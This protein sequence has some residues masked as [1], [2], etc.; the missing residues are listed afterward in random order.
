MLD[1]TGLKIFIVIFSVIGAVVTTV[2]QIIFSY[3]NN[4]KMEIFKVELTKELHNVNIIRS[5]YNKL[6]YKSIEELLDA[7]AE[8]NAFISEIGVDPEYDKD[9]DGTINEFKT[10]RRELSRKSLK[11]EVY[12]REDNLEI[13]NILHYY[14]S[15]ANITFSRYT[16][17]ALSV[18]ENELAKI[19]GELV[20][21]KKQSI[22]DTNL[23]D[24]LNHSGKLYLKLWEFQKELYQCMNT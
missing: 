14:A 19:K 10:L 12:I 17:F 20:D 4:K 7:I 2:I 16:K 3:R 1:E 23:D 24:F 5:E 15:K 13:A 6:K 18:K 8:M 11:A 21:N 22:E 9:F